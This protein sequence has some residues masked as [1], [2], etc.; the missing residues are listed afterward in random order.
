M[1]N[2]V[3]N[4][5]NEAKHVSENATAVMIAGIT[6]VVLGTIGIFGGPVFG[7]FAMEVFGILLFAAG[8][9]SFSNLQ[10]NKLGKTFW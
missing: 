3:V 5:R 10:K 2:N 6:S 8:V 9:V 7:V 1:A 4:L